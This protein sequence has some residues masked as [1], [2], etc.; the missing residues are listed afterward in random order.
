[1]SSCGFGLQNH[2]GATPKFFGEPNLRNFRHKTI[3][4]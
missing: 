3:S 2:R 4:K 1:M